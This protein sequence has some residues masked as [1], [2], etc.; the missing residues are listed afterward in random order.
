M[1]L[2][3]AGIGFKTSPQRVGWSTLE[4]LWR[5]AGE[6]DAFDSGWLN[7]HLVDTDPARPGPSFEGMTAL[8]ALA[9]HVPGR[10]VGH[11]VLANTFR[12]PAL[13]AKMATVLD[14]LTGGR[15]IL[16]LG[17]GWFEGEHEPYGI[18]LPPP[19]ER[20][21]RLVSAVA[22]LEALF[23]PAAGEPGGV[24]RPDPHYPLRGAVNLPLPLHPGGPPIYLG[25]QRRRGIALAAARAQGW[26]LPG[27]K[28]GDVAYFRDRR[29][30]ILR[31]MEEI[32]RD[33]AGFDFVA[34]VNA[35]TGPAD[36]RRA[37][38]E[39]EAF[40]AAGATSLI[41]GVA[42]AGGPALLTAAAREVAQ[43]LRDRV[44]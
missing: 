9:H 13:L 14:H 35:G 31:A 4:A 25:G 29:D 21:D 19:G 18:P 33:P 40:I 43:P 38:E 11:A 12:H 32:G 37:R 36:Y 23:S 42:A 41:V 22:V 2:G 26:I 6:L 20:I 24:T 10:W 1:G 16:G 15:F 27:V 30:A 34:Q 17:A 8:A 3:R 44:G 28:A 39:A 5:T 7:D